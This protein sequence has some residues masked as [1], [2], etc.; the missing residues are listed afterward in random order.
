MWALQEGWDNPNIFTLTK[1]AHSSSISSR[2]QQVG[3]GLRICVNS[4]GKRLTHKHLDFNDEKFLNTNSLDVVVSGYEADYIEGLQK[5]IIDSSFMITGK[6]F[7]EEKLA[8][9]G[10]NKNEI[11]QLTMHLNNANALEFDEESNSYKIITPIYEAMQNNESIK[12]AL[13]DKFERILNSFKPRDLRERIKNADNPSIKVAIRKENAKRFKELWEKINKNAKL[14][15]KNLQEEQLLDDI[16]REFSKVNIPKEYITYERKDYE[17]KT[18]RILLKSKERLEQ[19]SIEYNN[20]ITNDIQNLLLDFAKNNKLPLHFLLKIY[21]RLDKEKFQNSPKKAFKELESIIKESLHKNLISSISYDFAEHAFSN[22]DPLYETD[23]TPKEFIAKS[24]LGRE[25]SQSSETPAKNYLYS[26][27]VWDSQIEKNAIINEYEKIDGASIEVFAKLP[28]FRIQ[29]PYKSYEPDFA[30]LIK[31][32]DNKTIFFICETKGYDDL[33]EIP[34]QEQVK[35]D[36][37]EKFF[38]CLNKMLPDIEV[39]Y[40]TR[41]NNKDLR[42]LLDEVINQNKK[43]AK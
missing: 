43:D 4:E 22:D 26:Q 41:I 18:N 20:A 21:N 12:K 11:F 1:L 40:K 39:V 6:F 8:E 34:L 16:V 30:Y 36:Y 33:R 32:A 31:V 14:V 27:A 38:I 29:T 13:G 2:H 10:L 35:I 37:A 42:E 28:K 17:S 25:I 9:L 19:D 23:G 15:Y 24:M 7:D 3:R 5:E